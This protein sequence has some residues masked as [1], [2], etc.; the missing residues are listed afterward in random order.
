MDP[1]SGIRPGISSGAL[2]VFL[3][4][5]AD[6]R[7]FPRDRSFIAAAEAAVMRAGHAITDMA[8]FAARDSAPADTCIAKV[9]EAQVYVGII[10]HRYGATVRGR[11]EVSYTELEFETATRLGVP[12][13]IFMLR[14]DTLPSSHSAEAVVLTGRQHAFRQRLLNEA[15]LTI[16]W[17]QSSAELEVSL[18]H[19]LVELGVRTEATA[20]A[21]RTLPR[22]VAS[23]TGRQAEMERLLG[24]VSDT[25]RAGK[26]VVIS[27]IDGMAGV[28]KT[29][30]A[31]HAAHRLAREFPDGQLFLDLH[32]HTAGQRPVTSVDALG[33]LLRTIGLGPQAIPSD[34]DARAALW[35]DRLAGKRMLILFDD[36]AG[37]QQVRPLLP[38]TSDCLVLITSRRRLAGLED[39]QTLTLDTLTPAEAVGLFANLA[40]G[41]ARQADPSEIVDLVG[42][43]GH[44][45]LAIT[46]VAGRLRSHSSWTPRHLVEMLGDAQDRLAE[47]R[48]EDIAVDVAFELSYSHLTPDQ[49]RLFRQLGLHPGR[50]VDVYATAA[51]EDVDLAE[52]RR[53]LEALYD[54]HLV[55]EPLPGRFRMHDLIRDYARSLAASEDVVGRDAARDRLLDYFLRAVAVANAQLAPDSAT[56]AHPAGSGPAP[57][58][59]LLTHQEALDWLEGERANLGAV[60]EDAAARG[61]SGPAARLAHAMQPFLRIAGHWDQALAVHRAA[62]SAARAAGNSASLAVALTDLGEMQHYR[63]DYRV[64]AASLGEAIALCR[65]AG[66]A[67]GRADALNTLGLVLYK[68]N[69]YADAAASVTEALTL[70]RDLGDRRCQARALN[71]LAV[72]RYLT[73]EYGPVTA[74]LTEALALFRDLGDRQGQATSLI[75]LGIVQL[76][77]GR[78]LEADRS[79]T[80]SLSISREIG[81]RLGQANALMYEGVVRHRIGDCPTALVLLSEALT[82]SREIGS[83]LSQANALMYVGVTHHFAGECPVAAE[84]LRSAI[85]LYREL[86]N[87]QGEAE[88]LDYLGAVLLDSADGEEAIEH[89]RQALR[90]AREIGGRHEEAHALEGIGRCLIRASPT[91]DG[92]AHL[93]EALAIY[94]RLSV[95][96]AERVE[97]TLA[98]LEGPKPTTDD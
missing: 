72:A 47:L 3:S 77:T 5:T 76:L 98:E 62:A 38:G 88:S 86:G 34:V 57:R 93:R 78:Y 54:S 94:E 35:R 55:D 56:A 23:F 4:H 95:P 73:G 51:L 83:R 26:S 71:N 49:Q 48:I 21:T 20:V 17:V 36:A 89:H 28:G 43:C 66:D 19:A 18:V 70:Y 12:R 69:R 44:L 59:R 40:G 75:Y 30:F 45:P 46:L 80:Q 27:A 82:I 91:A 90:L 9:A 25:A 16:A 50:D 8:Y 96:E 24:T 2:R 15:E 31:V 53:R 7:E 65:D 29:A 74:H 97:A 79:L 1:H 84:S 61:R 58:P 52:A 6:L 32:G 63:G 11:P 67:R 41:R 39:V 14:N 92:I 10:G 68:T 87:R 22:D 60:M 81:Y 85:A 42:R 13:L 33:T 64:A 37:H